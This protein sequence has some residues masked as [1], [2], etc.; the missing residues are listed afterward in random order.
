MLVTEYT[1]RSEGRMYAVQ[2]GGGDKQ[3]R[4]KLLSRVTVVHTKTFWVEDLK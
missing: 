1:V 3:T 2:I 4:D